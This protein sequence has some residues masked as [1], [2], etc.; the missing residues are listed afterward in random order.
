MRFILGTIL[1]LTTVIT[2]WLMTLNSPASEIN[3]IQPSTSVE[4]S[5]HAGNFN[6]DNAAQPEPATPTD[7]NGH[8]DLSLVEQALLRYPSVSAH[9][10]RDLFHDNPELEKIRVDFIIA[11][12]ERGDMAADELIED[13][14][15]F[16]PFTVA[17]FAAGGA[18]SD[19]TLE[20][21]NKLIE[22]GADVNGE[23]LWRITMA[24]LQ[25]NTEVLE[26]WYRHAALG[27]EIHEELFGNAIVFGN[28]ALYDL[29]TKELGAH[30]ESNELWDKEIAEW[31][32]E[33]KNSIDKAAELKR[34][35][36]ETSAAKKVRRRSSSIYWLQRWHGQAKILQA[37][38]DDESER[39]E[40]EH[41]AAQLS[42]ELKELEQ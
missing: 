33:V 35:I 37:L 7:A 13:F 22:L 12:I 28:S 9:E 41:V 34:E 3:A 30:F 42:Q 20:Q 23:K 16:G 6:E 5:G 10:L 15:F 26:K 36:A 40:L 14:Q 27:P 17:H 32:N 11:L 25:R 21:F 19:L 24:R 38:S 4:L 18:S 39:A 2:I 8:N 29:L 31:T 1:V